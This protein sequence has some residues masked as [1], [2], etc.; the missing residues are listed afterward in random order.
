MAVLRLLGFKVR[1]RKTKNFKTLNCLAIICIAYNEKDWHVVVW[2][3][4]RKKV[5][6]PAPL[7]KKEPLSFYRKHTQFVLLLTR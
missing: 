4:K 6:D 1:K 3:P 7:N 2:D 5:L